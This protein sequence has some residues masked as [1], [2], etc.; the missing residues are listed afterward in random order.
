MRIL[1]T[2]ATGGL[3][4]NAVEYLHAHGIEIQ[5]TGRKVT[6]GQFFS[7]LCIPFTAIDLAHATDE[8]LSRLLDGVDVV[9]HC[10]ALSSP[11]GTR[12]L[13]ENSNVLATRNLLEASGKAGVRRFIH[14]STPAI[15]FDFTHRYNIV[16]SFRA[17][18][19]ANEYARTK[20]LGEAE[21]EAINTRFPKL[22]T[23]ILRPRAIFG[24]YDQVLIP[25]LAHM[26]SVKNGRLPLPRGGQAIIDMTFVENVVH[27]MWL[28]TTK[29]DLP[30]G[31][32]F[33]ITN[34]KPE[35]IAVVLE[36][37]FVDK[38]EQR[39]KILNIPYP[40]VALGARVMECIS[41]VTN[42]EPRLTRYSAGVLAY[43]MT[44]NIAHANNVLGYVPPVTLDEGIHRTAVWLRTHG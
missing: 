36:K 40:A 19:P 38:L 24:P 37:L 15:Y 39:M 3:G 28:A 17:S 21:V 23:S 18:T 16:E 7:N 44:L 6:T 33:N 43:D 14:I 29:D 9:W 32:A 30:S 34:D 35:R 12:Q 20:L 5:A 25:R 22:R 1:V 8:E 11:W 31:L 27:A 2:G 13:F 41:A 42:K 4:R 26:L 10:A